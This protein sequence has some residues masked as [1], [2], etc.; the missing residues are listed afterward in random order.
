MT[1]VLPRR[2]SE[3]HREL[4]RLHPRMVCAEGMWV[5]DD[6]ARE[7]NDATGG[8]AGYHSFLC[9]SVSRL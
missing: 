7:H 1:T 5:W 3:F 2:S 4:D 9:Y 6:E 8:G